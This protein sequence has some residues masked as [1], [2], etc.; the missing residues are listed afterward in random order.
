M[1]H[2]IRWAALAAA[3]AVLSPIASA[4]ETVADRG[5]DITEAQK[6]AEASTAAAQTPV[7]AD[8]L[9]AARKPDETPFSDI[10]I[11]PSF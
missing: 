5:R 7:A 4:A 10:K 9:Q 1:K 3:A 2:H 11:L 8:N 6:P